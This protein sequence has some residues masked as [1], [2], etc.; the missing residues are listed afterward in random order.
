MKLRYTWGPMQS[1]WGTEPVRFTS[2]LEA[3]QRSAPIVRLRTCYVARLAQ[4]IIQPDPY[5]VTLDDLVD[6]LAGSGWKP[7]TRKS[8]RSRIIAFYD[9]RNG[10]NGSTAGANRPAS[11]RRYRSRAAH[12][13][14]RRTIGSDVPSRCQ[15]S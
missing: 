2:Y 9:G 15:R 5:A 3:A 10:P 14:R 12:P 7:E 6:W 1:D 13:G 8:V 4:E 11:S